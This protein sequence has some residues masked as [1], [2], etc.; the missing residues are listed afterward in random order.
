MKPTT[1]SMVLKKHIL[2]R[3]MKTT[4]LSKQ[5][6]VP[7]GTLRQWKMG[8]R[9]PQNWEQIAQVACA[10]N[11]TK[12]EADELFKAIDEDLL[13]KGDLPREWSISGLK[14]RATQP[15][16]IRLLGY[17][18][19]PFLAPPKPDVFV[20]RDA[21]VDEVISILGQENGRRVCMLHGMAGVGKT[22]IAKQIV[23]LIQEQF[24]DGVLWANL[25]EE[26]AERWHWTLMQFAQVCRIDVPAK[27]PTDMLCQ[28][29][30]SVLRE[31]Q[32]LLILDDVQTGSYIEQIW[33]G[34]SK[35]TLLLTS[36]TKEIATPSGTE[37]VRLMSFDAET[38]ATLDLFRNYLGKRRVNREIDQFATIADLIGHLPLAAT[39]VAR[40]LEMDDDWLAAD[41]L[42]DVLRPEHERLEALKYDNLNVR[43]SFNLSYE[44]LGVNKQRFFADLGVFEGQPFTVEA[45]AFVWDKSLRSARLLLR[46][47]HGLALAGKIQDGRYQ[48]H[49][50]LSQFAHD[51]LSGKEKYARKVNYYINYAH[52]H[53]HNESML[54]TELDNIRLALSHAYNNQISHEFVRGV[55]TTYRIFFDHGLYE[56]VD[57]YLSQ[58]LDIAREHDQEQHVAQLL[59]GM[60]FVAIRRN[61]K[62]TAL[63]LIREA[64]SIADDRTRI[65]LGR[66]KGEIAFYDDATDAIEIF[67]IAIKL[68]REKNEDEELAILCYSIANVY[69]TVGQPDEAT[70]FIKECLSIV[71]RTGNMRLHSLLLTLQ[72]SIEQNRGDYK[73]AESSYELA[74]KIVSKIK[75]PGDLMTL[76][77]YFGY[78]LR[79]RGKYAPALNYYKLAMEKAVNL[80]EP[81]PQ[82]YLFCNMA[83]ILI[84]QGEYTQARRA[85]E[86]A[87]AISNQMNIDIGKSLLLLNQGR[88]SLREK[89]DIKQAKQLLQ[90]GL[91]LAEATEDVEQIIKIS[92]V[93]GDVYLAIM[94]I[95]SA[96]TQFTIACEQ[97]ELGQYTAEFWLGQYGLARTTFMSGE[98][99]L[100]IKEAKT[101]YQRLKEIGHFQTKSIDVW[102]NQVTK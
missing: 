11:L 65:I 71:E 56:T 81:Y 49:P 72:G 47:F 7:E 13:R 35:C 95:D 85:L 60:S 1:F 28:R 75:N 15:K 22:T 78:L 38:E 19:G 9:I 52:A 101:Y 16:E 59:L 45:A 27:L 62:D 96:R 74:L 31:K 30:R 33:P 98:Q 97:S 64:E 84:E 54:F 48:L 73:S 8:G 43:L 68:A 80:S 67:K 92:L 6:H 66:I 53:Q 21:I 77:M 44:K 82:L 63:A 69:V 40:R 55:A 91:R 46:D 23:H 36:R 5:S 99:E 93:L 18:Q 102:V 83:D 26:S 61:E 70:W 12:N 51:Y 32:L 17:W 57:T 3:G 10:L 90:Q 4:T 94:D 39:I 89:R 29:I 86:E 42:E 24:P 2:E 50:L 58:A 100:G 88:L 79:L 20:G 37:W 41:F 34:G 87:K 76:Y 25:Q 14:E